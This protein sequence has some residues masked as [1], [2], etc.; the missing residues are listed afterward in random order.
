M[1]PAPDRSAGHELRGHT[2]LLIDD[3][4]ANAGVISD[5]TAR[6]ACS[7]RARRARTSSCSM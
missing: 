1:T 4:P 3:D 7:K 6:A 2:V 5:A